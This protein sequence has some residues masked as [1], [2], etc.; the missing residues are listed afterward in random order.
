MEIKVKRGEQSQVYF[1]SA[2]T[3]LQTTGIAIVSVIDFPTIYKIIT[4]VVLVFSLTHVCFFNT[5]F[6]NKIIGFFN[7]VSQKEEIFHPK[8]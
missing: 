1:L 6:R 3:I 2:F 5:W 7:K 8:K 4:L